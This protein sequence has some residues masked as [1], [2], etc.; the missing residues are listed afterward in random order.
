MTITTG[1]SSSS[2]K[3]VGVGSP[4]SWDCRESSL[5]TS[6]TS[7]DSTSSRPTDTKKGGVSMMLHTQTLLV[8]YLLQRSQ[9]IPFG[10]TVS[11]NLQPILSYTVPVEQLNKLLGVAPEESSFMGPGKTADRPAVLSGRV[12]KLQRPGFTLHRTCPLCPSML[13]RW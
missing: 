12:T 10:R 7:R 13:A 9:Y 2:R 4:A 5:P 8:P 1:H 6:V 3:T 11:Q